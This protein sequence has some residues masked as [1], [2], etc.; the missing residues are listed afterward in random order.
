MKIKISKIENI[1]GTLWAI[2]II[3]LI[4][5]SQILLYYILMS[6]GKDPQA[7]DNKFIAVGIIIFSFIFFASAVL[8]GFRNVKKQ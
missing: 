1:K 8:N 7:K 6:F 2:F 5:G 3:S 4:I